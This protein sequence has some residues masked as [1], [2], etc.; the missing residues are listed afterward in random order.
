MNNVV[1]AGRV[2]VGTDTSDAARAAVDWAAARAADLGIPLLIMLAVAPSPG[3]GVVPGQPDAAV[4]SPFLERL[5]EAA[6]Q[7]ADTERSRLLGVHPK[8][9][10]ETAVV[11]AEPSYPLASATKDAEIVVVGARGYSAPL[12]TT[13]LGG[14]SDAVATHAHGPVA[15]I[16]EYAVR[17]PA[18]ADG[19]VVVG[20]DDSEESLA[21]IAWAAAEAARR[22]V[23]L[24][25]VHAWRAWPWL[26]ETL[27]GWSVTD[28]NLGMGLEQMVKDLVTP[29]L[30]EGQQ[31][32]TRV[33]IGHPA[34]KLL[35][36]SAD[37]S[38]VVIGSRGRGGLVGMLLGSTSREVM[39]QAS[40][41]VVVV[42]G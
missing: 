21:A 16:P 27:V 13:A 30:A 41:P 4:A 5:R 33:S 39:R 40:S 34:V 9:V 29:Y 28:A 37:A 1:T 42:R 7:A 19:P 32:E 24:V 20:V 14:T 12:K 35:E 15:V 2:V 6:Q 23:P 17:H 38:V 8:L 3:G 25:A 18:H 11:I 26:T 36:A 10:V 22:S 31:F